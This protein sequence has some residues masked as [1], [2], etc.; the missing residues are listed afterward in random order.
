MQS[1]R[2]LCETRDQSKE[3]FARPRFLKSGRAWHARRQKPIGAILHSS[4]LWLQSYSYMIGQEL[5]QFSP[6]A[7]S[8]PR[9]ML[10]PPLPSA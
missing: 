6:A 1:Q 8:L 10:L 4:L 5:L 2:L 7:L 9:A 3:G